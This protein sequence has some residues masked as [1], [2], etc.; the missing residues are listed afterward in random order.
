MNPKLLSK[1]EFARDC[2]VPILLWLLQN[3]DLI[4]P[5]ALLFLLFRFVVH[6]EG[7]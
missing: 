1:I 7:R 3:S 4:V 2:L 6:E 5:S